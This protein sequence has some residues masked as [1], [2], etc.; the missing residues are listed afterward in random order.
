MSDLK[1]YISHRQAQDPDFNDGYDDGYKTFK[2][3]NLLH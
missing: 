1:Q 3:S 2:I